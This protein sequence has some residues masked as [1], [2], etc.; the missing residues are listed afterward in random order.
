V[1][2]C[3]KTG[4]CDIEAVIAGPWVSVRGCGKTGRCDE[5]KLLKLE[6]NRQSVR[7][8]GKTGHCD[9]EAVIAGPWVSVRGCG[10]TGHCTPRDRIAPPGC[11]VKVPCLPLRSGL[12]VE[13]TRRVGQRAT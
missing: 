3:G 7:G 2:G 5:A 1:R 13:A 8:C 4:H 11:C 10:K 12:A 9:I 6:G